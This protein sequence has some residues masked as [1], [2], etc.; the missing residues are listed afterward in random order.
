M[1]PTT[2]QSASPEYAPV[3]IGSEHE[4]SMERKL[5]VSKASVALNETVAR[6]IENQPKTAA[7][8]VEVVATV[9]NVEQT[10]ITSAQPVV[11]P[12]YTVESNPVPVAD[13]GAWN[14]EQAIAQAQALVDQLSGNTTSA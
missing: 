11:T 5:T 7:Q 13:N 10:P 14:R 3:K 12:T 9:S 1:I 6:I 8:P 4:P 2:T